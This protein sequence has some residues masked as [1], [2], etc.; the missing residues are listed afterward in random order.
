MPAR[1]PLQAKTPFVLDPRPLEEASSP[2]A[3]ALTLSRVFRSLELPAL[4]R[5]NLALKQ[6]QRGFDE[7]QMIETIV[8]LQVIGGDCPE[9]LRLLA[10]DPC[11]ERGLGHRPPRA[12]AVRGF[13]ERF[14]D[15]ELEP[16]RPQGAVQKS[17]ILPSSGPVQGLQQ[18]QAGGGAADRPAL[19]AARP[20]PA[21]RDD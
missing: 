18:V 9:D 20:G 19:R 14:H 1:R 4:I 15:E 3:R 11:L 21:D 8:L 12:A 17:F 13:L 16:Q 10:Q 6:R 5:A 2:H 7:G